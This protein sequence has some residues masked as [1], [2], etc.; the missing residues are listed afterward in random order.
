MLADPGT[1]YTIKPVNNW[2]S[3][4]IVT[5]VDTLKSQPADWKNMLFPEAAASAGG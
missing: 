2:I 1:L 5:N 3:A 4:E